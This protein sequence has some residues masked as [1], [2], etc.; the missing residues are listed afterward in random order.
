LKIKVECDK[1]KYAK[2]TYEYHKLEEV[3]GF[4][5]GIKGF[6]KPTIGAWLLCVAKDGAIEGVHTARIGIAIH[7]DS[8]DYQLAQKIAH[9]V[10]LIYGF[11]RTST[12]LDVALAF[13]KAFDKEISRK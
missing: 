3:F 8:F 13:A 12:K 2:G 11:D 1:P 4:L 9:K 6:A 10:G 7:S 5:N